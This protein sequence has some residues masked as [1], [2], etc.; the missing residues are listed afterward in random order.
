MTENNTPN[1]L[2][3]GPWTGFYEEY[4][5]DGNFPM[6]CTLTFV[7]GLISGSGSD[8]V[9][10]FTFSG[11]YTTSDYK[12]T[13]RKTYHTHSLLYEGDA[14]EN[15]IWGKWSFPAMKFVSAGFHIWPKKGE[16]ESIEEELAIEEAIEDLLEV[17]EPVSL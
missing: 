1:F 12:V 16:T 8:E 4:A 2:P 11:T 17:E 9:G 6:S 15:G 7:D 14:D 5:K 3:D 13:M 10:T